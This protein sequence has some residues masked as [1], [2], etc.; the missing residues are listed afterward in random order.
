MVLFRVTWLILITLK[1]LIFLLP[2]VSNSVLV[3]TYIFHAVASSDSKKSNNTTAIIGAAAGV[4]VLVLILI[5]IAV[6]AVRRKKKSEK[7]REQSQ[8]FG[9]IVKF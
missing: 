6:F 2:C 3:G 7:Y 5:V 1:A 8:P 4:A 9:K